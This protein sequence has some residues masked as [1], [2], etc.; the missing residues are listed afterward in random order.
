[1]NHTSNRSNHGS[2]CLPPVTP[3]K[4][5]LV[6]SICQTPKHSIRRLNNSTSVRSPRFHSCSSPS[7]PLD[8]CHS[9]TSSPFLKEDRF[10]PNRSRVD[11]PRA[12]KALLEDSREARDD[13]EDDTEYKR[14][15]RR[16]LFGDDLTPSSTPK[17]ILCLAGQHSAMS[18][19]QE[20]ASTINP[21]NL[22]VLRSTWI[23]DVPLPALPRKVNTN[24]LFILDASGVN[25]RDDLHVLSVGP[26]FAVALRDK[27]AF[28]AY[29][30]HA[31]EPG[32]ELPRLLSTGVGTVTSLQWRYKGP[33]TNTTSRFKY[34][35]AVGGQTAVEVF[36]VEKRVRLGRAGDHKDAVTSLEW[37]HADGTGNDL[38]LLASS[39]MGIRRYDLRSRIPRACTYNTVLGAFRDAPAAKM[40]IQPG[41]EQLLAAV[42]PTKN[43]VALWDLRYALIPLQTMEHEKVKGLEFCPIHRNTLA[44]GGQ[45]GIRLW[46]VQSGALRSVIKTNDPVATLTW[47]PHQH[48]IMAGSGHYLRLWSVSPFFNQSQL[49]EQWKRPGGGRVIAMER[50]DDGPETRVLSLHAA[51]EVLACWKPFAPKRTPSRDLDTPG[52]TLACSPIIR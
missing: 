2:L 12:R 16:T 19:L 17:S 46:N 8:L 26:R 11:T 42:I 49:L 44:T 24:H 34:V 21:A 3:S 20:K 39:S 29:G 43:M 4:R 37:L 40:Q 7:T 27:V 14:H 22:D 45:D 52:M 30:T 5:K 48:E 1:M 28:D 33:N 25:P 9:R 18:T 41:N 10:I 38:E 50:M 23:P 51:G 32:P 47:S 36:D 15:L 6:S 31:H 35:L 13:V